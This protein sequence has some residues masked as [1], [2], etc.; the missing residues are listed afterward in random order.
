[1][2]QFFSKDGTKLACWQTGQGEPLLLVHGTSGDHLGWNLLLAELAAHF[3]VWTF[4]RRG[5]ADSGDHSCY[6]LQHE[7]E[8]IA[9]VL[10]AIGT[11]VHLF[12]HSFGGLCALETSLITEKIASLMLYEPPLSLEG[13]GWSTELDQQMQTLL[14]AGAKEQVVLLFFREVL[15]ISNE[16]LFALQISSS[17]SMRIAE[18][19][20]V[21]REL[22]AISRY[23]FEAS[24]F[25]AL[26]IPALI[27]LGSESPPRRHHIANILKNSLLNSQLVLLEGQQHSAIRTAPKL[28]ADRVRQFTN[29]LKS[30]I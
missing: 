19:H 4:D 11:K 26:K 22:Q 29:L 16:E 5:R 18:A 24:K 3:Q 2:K 17:W 30:N 14:N 28:L 6:S 20:T 27:L 8:D 21:H 15:R 9:A 25:Q 12:A 13:S 7:A 23:Q 1:M 10:A